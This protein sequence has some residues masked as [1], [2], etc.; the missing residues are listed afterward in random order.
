VGNTVK[1]VPPR[2]RTE[3]LNPGLH[4]TAQ[5]LKMPASLCLCAIRQMGW[6]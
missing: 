3:S 2:E 5:I 1:S 4:K 6:R